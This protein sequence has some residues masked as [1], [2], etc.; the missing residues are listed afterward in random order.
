MSQFS[1]GARACEGAVSSPSE[2][3]RIALS[4][5]PLGQTV[6]SQIAQSPNRE[7][8]EGPSVTHHRHPVDC[9]HS[10]MVCPQEVPCDVSSG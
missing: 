1:S 2:T 9:Y 4:A 7:S 8:A 6:A 10:R 5:W 3:A